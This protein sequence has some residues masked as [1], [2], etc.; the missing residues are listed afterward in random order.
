ME[1]ASERLNMYGAP[2]THPRLPWVWVEEQLAAAATYWVVVQGRTHP[3]PRPVWGV[4]TDQLLHLSIGS[5]LISRSLSDESELSVH[6]DS[7]VD[8]VI[9]EGRVIGRTETGR[10]L[11]AYDEKYDWTYA[12]DE[13]GPLTT[14][15]PSTVLAWRCT[16]W[17][18]RDGF[19]QTGR[20]RFGNPPH[21][22]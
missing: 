21:R 16:G 4:W 22:M 12:V 5:P 8:V 11:R 10:V 1:P 7:G 6:L 18:G 2:T 13:Y 15:A 19:Q 9:V 3:H 17:A 14:I 20:W